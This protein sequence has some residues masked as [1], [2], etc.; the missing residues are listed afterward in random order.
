M[1]IAPIKKEVDLVLS[2]FAGECV[3][4]HLNVMFDL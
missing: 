2:L 1:L 3:L 4:S